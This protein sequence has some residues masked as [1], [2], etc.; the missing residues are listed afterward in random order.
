MGWSLSWVAVNGV[1]P[2]AVQSALA[3][4]GTG[5]REEFPESDI[6]GTMLP[7]GWYLVVSQRDG[8]RLTEDS[9]LKR[10]SCLGEVVMCWVEEHVMC[11]FA[12]CWRD[13]QRIWSVN[14]D[15]GRGIENFV[16]EGQHPDSFTQIHDKLFAKQAAAGGKTARLTAFSTSQWNWHNRLL[17]TATIKTS[18]RC[19]R[20]GSKFL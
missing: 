20:T 9:A 19:A 5:S 2:Q 11:S 14:H 15:S 7:G 3:L 8:L 17:A 12:A 6:T 10:L 16:V 1:T 4:R 13:G 18:T